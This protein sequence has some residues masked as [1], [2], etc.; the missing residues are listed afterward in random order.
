M[1]A[2][3]Q[4]EANAPDLTFEQAISMARKNNVSLRVDR[5]K[6]SQAQANVDQAWSALFPTVAGQAKYTHNYK[7]V[8]LNFGGSPL[9][10]QPSE[11]FDFAISATAPIIAPAAYSALEAVKA[12]V[13]AAEA[14]F[15]GQEASVL[16]SAAR[17]FLVAAGDDELVTTRRS[18]LEVARATRRDAQVRLD[19]GSV[20]KVDVD[21]AELAVVRAEQ[22]DRETVNSRESAYRT[23]STLIG[24]EHPF[25]VNANFPSAPMPDPRDLDLALRLRPEFQ[26]LQSLVKAADAET[27]AHAWRWAPSISAFGNARKFNYDNFARDRHAWA[28][29]GQLDWLLF[30][31]GTRDADR[32]R[33][34]AR[35][36]EALAQAEVLRLRIRDDLANESSFLDT[37]RKGV[38]SAERSVT[39]A[40]ESL[41]L[42]R[43]QYEAGTGTQLDLLTAQDAVVVAH[44]QLVQAHFDVAAAD[45]A[46]RYSAGTFPPKK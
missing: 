11:Q 40:H 5:A 9:L 33:A 14:T 30:D 41:D 7:E 12:S 37:K 1:P 15:E 32:H 19:A 34:A 38:E 36:E 43:T 45:L 27:R 28:V 44:L 6:L 21:R 24:A 18:S 2:S 42:I 3:A 22:L 31:G 4:E 8:A 26:A 13:K 35:G 20:T 17:A 39:L 23:L 25:K 29:G 16:V 10:L 46:L